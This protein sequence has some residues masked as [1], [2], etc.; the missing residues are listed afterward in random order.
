MFPKK[1]MWK[2]K[3]MKGKQEIKNE[4]FYLRLKSTWILWKALVTI[5]VR[6]DTM[7]FL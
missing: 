1:K 3:K 7:K 6:I 4:D 2:E 5:L